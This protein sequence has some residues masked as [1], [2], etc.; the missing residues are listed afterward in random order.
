MADRKLMYMYCLL[1]VS[2]LCCVAHAQLST[3]FY[4]TT[5]NESLANANLPSSGASLATL[6]SMFASQGLSHV[7]VR[8]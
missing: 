3:T 8:D 1:A 4:S 2:L 6:I 5:A 7:R